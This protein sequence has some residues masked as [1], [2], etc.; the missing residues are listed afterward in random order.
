MVQNRLARAQESAHEWLDSAWTYKDAA[1]GYKK[2]G[3]LYKEGLARLELSSVLRA[4]GKYED[5]MEQIVLAEEISETKRTLIASVMYNK[6]LV[7]EGMGRQRSENVGTGQ[8]QFSSD[9]KRYNL[10]ST[11]TPSKSDGSDPR[12][13]TPAPISLRM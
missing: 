11:V 1:E 10:P 5:A 13:T 3:K 2:A 8:S 12:R 6:V 4:M 9:E 7:Y